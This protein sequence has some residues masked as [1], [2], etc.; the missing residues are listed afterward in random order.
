MGNGTAA[1]SVMEVARVLPVPGL[2]PMGRYRLHQPTLVLFMEGGRHVARQIPAESILT[3]GRDALKNCNASFAGEKLTRAKWH[4]QEIMM[5][6]QDLK[7]KAD[8]A[9]VDSATEMPKTLGENTPRRNRS[10]GKPLNRSDACIRERWAA[11]PLRAI[12]PLGH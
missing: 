4:G 11:L 7:S 6:T 2:S 8:L 5:F 10:A 1:A 9:V 3:V 12:R